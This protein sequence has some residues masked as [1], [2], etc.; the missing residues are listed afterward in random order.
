MRKAATCEPFDKLLDALRHM[1][2]EGLDCLSVVN[3]SRRPL[4]V[5]DARDGARA[6]GRDPA[7]LADLEVRSAMSGVRGACAPTDS[8]VDAMAAME[9]LGSQ[10]LAVVDAVGSLVGT[11]SL[12][13][14]AGVLA[15]RGDEVEP[16]R[17]A[18]CRVLASCAVST[19]G[20]TPLSAVAPWSQELRPLEVRDVMTRDIVACRVEDSLAAAARRMSEVGVGCL[21]V[22]GGT[23]A[24]LA[25]V[26][27]DLELCRAVVRGCSPEA[28]RVGSVVAELRCACWPDDSLEAAEAVMRA[29]Y[30]C[31]IPVVTPAGELVGIVAS[32]DIARALLPGPRDGLRRRLLESYAA[33]VEPHSGGTPSRASRISRRSPARRSRSSSGILRPADPE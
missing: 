16:E 31:C 25:G 9:Q 24:E 10:R 5:L 28:T 23:G 18:A 14:V 20:W 4:G 29:Y 15:E 2:R 22:L 19:G 6:V 12:R 8:L 13:D 33:A 21:P 32:A 26:L 1:D 27:T 11:I 3:A 30:A 7:G 17:V